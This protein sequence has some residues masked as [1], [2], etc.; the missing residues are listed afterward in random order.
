VVA[1]GSAVT[2][3]N[4]LAQLREELGTALGIH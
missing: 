3:A 1:D 4:R 2:A